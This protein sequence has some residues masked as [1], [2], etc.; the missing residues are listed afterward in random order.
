MQHLDG[1]DFG[2]GRDEIVGEGPGLELAGVVVDELLVERRGDA[3]H[4]CAAHLAVGDQRIEQ[5]PASC[6]E[7]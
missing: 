7:M 1:R 6:I 5:L 4:E 3:L 2:D